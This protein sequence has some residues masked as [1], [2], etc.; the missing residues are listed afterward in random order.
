MQTVTVT[1]EVDGVTKERTT[2]AHPKVLEKLKAQGWTVPAAATQLAKKR[3]DA[4]A[5][6]FEAANS[7]AAPAAKKE[8]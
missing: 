3:Q 4:K 7:K 8:G 2:A 6:A 1:M 5:A